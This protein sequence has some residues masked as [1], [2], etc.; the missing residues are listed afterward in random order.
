MGHA[1]NWILFLFYLGFTLDLDR[2]TSVDCNQR[3]DVAS[4]TEFQTSNK[5][6]KII[7]DS[8][9]EKRGIRIRNSSRLTP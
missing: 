1:G 3:I 8:I 6:D 9:Y 2:E 4:I 7:K 5:Q